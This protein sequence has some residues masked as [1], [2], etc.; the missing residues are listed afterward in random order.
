VKARWF[1][2]LKGA[3]FHPLKAYKVRALPVASNFVFPKWVNLY[4]RYAAVLFPFAQLRSYGDIT[5]ISLFSFAAVLVL[6]VLIMSA[7]SHVEPDAA[8]GGGVATTLY[9]HHS[10][11]RC[12]SHAAGLLFLN[13]FFQP[14][15]AAW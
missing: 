13:T 6:V 15:F 7:S 1:Q 10:S 8:V 11:H 2:P 4:H 12:C 3:W 14:L 5:A 9:H